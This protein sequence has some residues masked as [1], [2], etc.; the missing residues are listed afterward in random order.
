MTSS[1]RRSPRAARHPTTVRHSTYRDQVRTTSVPLFPSSSGWLLRRE[2][3]S[4]GVVITAAILLLASAAVSVQVGGTLGSFFGLC[5]VL[6]CLTGALG[7]CDRAL[8][9][10]A[11]LP[12]L[13]LLAVVLLVS[14]LAPDAVAGDTVSSTA[15]VAARTVSGVVDLAAAL[16]LGHTATLAVVAVRMGTPLRDI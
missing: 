15:N 5:F 1:C 7:A 8:F 3:S 4:S 9:T 12:P 2:L 6:V 13:A 11:V 10:A 16:V 14:A